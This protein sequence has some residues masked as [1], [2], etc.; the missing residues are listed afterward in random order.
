MNQKIIRLANEKYR[1]S[2]PV[3]TVEPESISCSVPSGATEEVVINVSNSGGTV[4]NGNAV[5]KSRFLKTTQPEFSGVKNQ[6]VIEISGEYLESGMKYS[7]NV[8]L[9]TDCGTKNVPVEISTSSFEAGRD[10]DIADADTFTEFAKNDPDT[11]VRI[12]SSSYFE[13]MVISRSRK[14]VNVY[15][16]LKKSRDMK[17][18]LEEFLISAGKKE[19]LSVTPETNTCRIAASSGEETK[20]GAVELK[21]DGW[22]YADFRVTVSGDFL[23]VPE[24]HFT[25]EDFSSDGVYC[26]DFSCQVSKLHKGSNF[27]LITLKSAYLEVSVQVECR[28]MTDEKKVK[29][30]VK[31]LRA[32]DESMKLSAAFK[33]GEIDLRYYT[34]R[35]QRIFSTLEGLGNL[36]IYRMQR[37]EIN[38]CNHVEQYVEDFIKAFEKD[39]ERIFEEKPDIYAMYHYILLDHETER[40][41]K[42]KHRDEIRRTLTEGNG[43]WF[44]LSIAVVS[45][46]DYGTDRENLKRLLEAMTEGGSYPLIFMA[47]L[48]ILN[49]NPRVFDELSDNLQPCL[50]WGCRHGILE[51]EPAERYA[52]FIRNSRDFSI[53]AFRDMSAL[54]EKYKT[55]DFLSTICTI[56]I[57]GR[58]ENPVYHEWYLRGIKHG[59]R[60][61]GLYEYFMYSCDEDMQDEIP[62]S[63]LTYFKYDNSLKVSEKA[64]LYADI[65][66]KRETRPEVYRDYMEK[67]REFSLEQLKEGRINRNLA[68]IYED[69]VEKNLT[70]SRLAQDLVPLLFTYEIRVTNSDIV[71][72]YVHHDH[73]RTEEFVPVI[74]GRAM[75]RLYSEN[76]VILPADMR[77]VK[78]PGSTQFTLKKLLHMDDMAVECF[79]FVKDDTGLLLKLFSMKE[80]GAFR[81]DDGILVQK[82]YELKNKDD[83]FKRKLFS[84]IIKKYN[85]DQDYTGLDAALKDFSWDRVDRNEAALF[86]KILASRHFYDKVCEGAV[87]YGCGIVDIKILSEAVSRKIRKTG[88]ADSDL[89]LICMWLFEKEIR[90]RSIVSYLASN[91]EGSLDELIS[92]YHAARESGLDVFSLAEKILV[93]SVSEATILHG[94]YNIFFEYEKNPHANRTLVA[95]FMNVNAYGYLVR[96]WLVPESVFSG[97]ERNS[98]ANN[99]KTC[100]IALLKYL[101]TK[102]QLT[103]GELDFVTYRLRKLCD[104]RIYFDF[105]KRFAAVFPLPEAVLNYQF[106]EYTADPDNICRITMN[107]SSEGSSTGYST[108]IMQDMFCGIRVKRVVLFQN[109]LLQYYISEEDPGSGRK[110]ITE[111]RSVCYDDSQDSDNTDD[112]YHMINTMLFAMEMHEDRTFNELL[113]EFTG[114]KALVEAFRD[115]FE[116]SRKQG[117][118][119]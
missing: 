105:Y 9:V 16:G 35:C 44:A 11:A 29:K 68:V 87:R 76:D 115:Y 119:T 4:V 13:D 70:D 28:Y 30:D 39:R 90:D 55:D 38:V 85:E 31:E 102:K 1:Y 14:L 109:E 62:E 22:G 37:F 63:V 95:A 57:R 21:L 47:V 72:I 75:V 60:I 111:S 69:T 74:Q 17:A 91:Y 110:E 8:L 103:S 36:D 114:K 42:I 116:G 93:L 3:L 100:T 73:L 7:G 49:K 78:Y 79:R 5:S 65:I 118:R 106:I 104:E 53:T 71:G 117:G 86:A 107:V 84:S 19:K 27:G 113:N 23:K 45:D 43:S 66:K 2:V 12:F 25:T 15:R 94:E 99:S 61:T 48:H 10:T 58:R 18:A 88:E 64:M 34:Q 32:L 6:I 97:F 82:C 51:R 101:S 92:I 24:N 46:S 52:Y 89:L 67:I 50:H 80:R 96:N 20:E 54:Y 83:D 40:N 56:L 112:E 59:L 81:D 26:L 98:M 108:E 33:C 77:G 41:E